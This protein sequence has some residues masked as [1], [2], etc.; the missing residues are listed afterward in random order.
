MAPM[1]STMARVSRKI[2]NEVETRVPKSETTPTANA[3]SVA[4]GIPQPAVA[5]PDWL[6]AK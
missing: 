4:I 3:I 6:K 1:S 5:S 2:F